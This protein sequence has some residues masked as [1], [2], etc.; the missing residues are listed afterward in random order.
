MPLRE[1]QKSSQAKSPA[2]CQ[3]QRQTSWLHFGA[4]LI[5]FVGALVPFIASSSLK[6]SSH[7]IQKPQPPLTIRIQKPLQVKST[8]PLSIAVDPVDEVRHW[9]NFYSTT[10]RGTFQ[11]WL[12]RSSERI[13]EIQ[14]ILASQGLP[15]DLA[16][17]VMIESGFQVNAVSPKK[18]VG[19]WQFMKPTGKRFGLTIN[20]WLDERRNYSKSSVAAAKYLKVLFQ[21]FQDWKLATAS[22]N[23]GENY[24][25]R[26]TRNHDTKSFW[27]LSR[28]GALY[29]ETR[30]YVPKFLAALVIAKA[31]HLYGFKIPSPTINKADTTHIWVPGGTHL[32][33]IAVTAGLSPKELRE[34]NAELIRGYVPHYVSQFRIQIPLKASRPISAYLRRTIAARERTPDSNSTF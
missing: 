28:A 19:P 20:E 25:K 30:D 14:K 5:L 13:I 26:I 7:E 3:A 12:N 2:P 11:R 18:A 21:E 17:M 10:G 15:K 16:Y 27:R 22:Y 24:I 23:A 1:A 6:L 32:D 34:L 33:L 31:P 8:K 4:P 9:V 29:D